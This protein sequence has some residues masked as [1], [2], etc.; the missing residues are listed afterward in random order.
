MSSE[1][2]CTDFVGN[3]TT[4]TIEYCEYETCQHDGA[5]LKTNSTL[6]MF[7]YQYQCSKDTIFMFI[8]MWL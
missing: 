1:P 3:I 2:K 7:F 4:G 5:N 8:R 6:F